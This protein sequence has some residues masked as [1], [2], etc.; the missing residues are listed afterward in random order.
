MSFRCVMLTSG[1]T[2][3]HWRRP[4]RSI[5]NHK[6]RNAHPLFAFPAE[7]I[8]SVCTKMYRTSTSLKTFHS[9]PPMRSSWWQSHLDSSSGN[10][11]CVCKTSCHYIQW[12]LDSQS[13]VTQ[14]HTFQRSTEGCRVSSSSQKQKEERKKKKRP[15]KQQKSINSPAASLWLHALVMKNIST[16]GTNPFQ[17]RPNEA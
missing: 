2:Y 14:K 1:L 6:Q 8:M 5:F 15:D 13:P 9:K 10:H 17:T 11:E 7:M 12:S 3:K 16:L 4:G